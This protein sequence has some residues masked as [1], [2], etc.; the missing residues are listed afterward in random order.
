MGGSG[1][2]WEWERERER[3]GEMNGRNYSRFAGET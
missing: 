3:V 2:E 1:W